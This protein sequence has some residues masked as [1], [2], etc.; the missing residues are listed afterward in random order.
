MKKI[1]LASFLL[2]PGLTLH[3]QK[4][5][6]PVFTYG[7]DTVYNTEFERI[8]SKNNTSKEKLDEKTIR[9][10][11]DLFVNFKLKVKEARKLGLDTA[12]T[13]KSELEGYKKQLAQ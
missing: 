6:K 13:F 7:T 1:F 9:E 8:Y 11:L 4:P 3:A 12:A 5:V 2:L 10:Y